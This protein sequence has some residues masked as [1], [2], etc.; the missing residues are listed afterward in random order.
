MNKYSVYVGMLETKVKDEGIGFGQEPLK[1]G[2]LPTSCQVKTV[3]P[4]PLK[5]TH[6]HKLLATSATCRLFYCNRN[7]NLLWTYSSFIFR[8]DRKIFFFFFFYR[9]FFKAHVSLL[10]GFKKRTKNAFYLSLSIV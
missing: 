2:Q 7:E 8:R 5:Y 4:G 6:I 9:L 1:E 10:K 3:T